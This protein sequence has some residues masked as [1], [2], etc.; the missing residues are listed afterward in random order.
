MW[1]NESTSHA[2]ELSPGWRRFGPVPRVAGSECPSSEAEGEEGRGWEDRLPWHRTGSRGSRD[3]NL[4]SAEAAPCV[5]PTIYGAG[6]GWSRSSVQH[7]NTDRLQ[8]PPNIPT[9]NPTNR[10]SAC[11]VASPPARFH[12]RARLSPLAGASETL[13]Q[14]V[15]LPGGDSPP[16]SS[17]S[18]GRYRW[19]ASGRHAGTVSRA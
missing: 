9:A 2:G 5:T 13:S 8:L 16:C 11:C 19:S 18:A 17:S 6:G 7:I 14:P 10:D 3:G 1:T 12:R 15:P 4:R